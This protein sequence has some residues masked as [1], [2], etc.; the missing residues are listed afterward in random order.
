VTAPEGL[1]LGRR[2]DSEERSDSCHY[3]DDRYNQSTTSKPSPECGL[4]PGTSPQARP[5]SDSTRPW[6][7][8]KTRNNCS[9]LNKRHKTSFPT[10]RLIV[11]S[12]LHMATITAK[13]LPTDSL[14]TETSNVQAET[15]EIL[16]KHI[17]DASAPPITLQKKLHMQF[18]ARNLIQGFPARYTSQDASQ[19][20]LLFWTIQSF[21]L[22]GV[23]LDEANNQRCVGL[24]I[25]F[26]QH[27]LK[28][29]RTER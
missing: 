19:P 2:N 3:R 10:L 26:V 11:P 1:T 28:I 15:E 4:R 22:L 18:L 21:S 7:W 14:P 24:T 17:P 5:F 23:C 25:H 20:W 9:R 12:Q 13:P 8:R 6:L 27:R 16:L 29:F